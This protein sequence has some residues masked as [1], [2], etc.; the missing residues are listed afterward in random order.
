MLKQTI[1]CKNS[2]SHLTKCVLLLSVNQRVAKLTSCKFS[3]NKIF[4]ILQS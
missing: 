3:I 4:I 1:V 2:L